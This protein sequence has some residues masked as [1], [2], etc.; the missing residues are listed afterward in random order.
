MFPF[1]LRD[2]TAAQQLPDHIAP[3]VKKQRAAEAAALSEE[4]YDDY[5]RKWTGR[6]VDVL[7]EKCEDGISYGY[8]SEYVPAAV[9]GEYPV[10]RIVH[11]HAV[12]TKD[13]RL[14]CTGVSYEA[15]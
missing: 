2:G 9:E 7:V 12:D 8:T 4:L 15:E 14:I 1:S 5:R 13:H 11:V 3:A 6:D 10:G